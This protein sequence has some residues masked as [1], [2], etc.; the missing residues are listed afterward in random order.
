V[1][2]ALDTF[3]HCIHDSTDLLALFDGLNT[4]PPPSNAEVLKRASLV[5]AFTA[6]ETYIEDR[7]TEAAAAVAKGTQDSLLSTFYTAS[8]SNDI[9]YFHTPSTQRVRAIF[10]KYLLVDVTLGWEWNNYDIPRAKAELDKL[11]SKRG[12]VVHRSARP[13]EQT[14]TAHAVTREELKKIIRFTKD[15]VTATDKFLDSK[16]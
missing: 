9:K 2:K 3:N 5:M 15:L 1:S 16:F 6:L 12:D 7:I 13:R 4:N 11:A 14:P 8:L 10:L